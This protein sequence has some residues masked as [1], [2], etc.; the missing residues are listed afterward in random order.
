M[1]SRVSAS[2]T[3]D[4]SCHLK[5]QVQNWS[6]L[7]HFVLNDISSLKKRHVVETLKSFGT[8]CLLRT[9]ATKMFLADRIMWTIL[10]TSFYLLF[11]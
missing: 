3:S 9:E 10:K 6:I 5:L 7:R 11:L 2:I 1:H 4:I 8:I